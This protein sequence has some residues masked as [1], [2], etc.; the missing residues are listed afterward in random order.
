MIKAKMT[1]NIM[2]K[3]DNLFGLSKKQIIITVIAF[4]IGVGMY[5]LLRDFMSFKL[6][7]TLIFCELAGVIC[8][9]VINIQGMSLWSFFVKS[10]KGAEVYFYKTEGIFSDIEKDNKSISRK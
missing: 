4:A 7:S 9:G 10:M 3:N 5:F 6:L 1:K 8:F 2:K